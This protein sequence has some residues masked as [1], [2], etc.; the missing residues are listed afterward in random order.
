MKLTMFTLSL[1]CS[2]V[3]IFGVFSPQIREERSKYLLLSDRMREI[4]TQLEQLE[5]ERSSLKSSIQAMK[6]RTASQPSGLQPSA[7]IIQW[8]KAGDFSDVPAT[9]SSEL[10]NLLDL[11]GREAFDY[12]L[13]SKSTIETF[14]ISACQTFQSSR[15]SEEVCA[16][17]A[18]NKDERRQVDFAVS[19]GRETQCHM[20]QTATRQVVLRKFTMIAQQVFELPSVHKGL[21][22]C[23]SG[24]LLNTFL[25]IL[26]SRRA[27]KNN[28]FDFPE[29][30]PRSTLSSA[31][32]SLN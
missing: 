14:D 27:D 19:I 23:S 6:V 22:F 8:L 26:R 32:A 1:T 25:E 12:L 10:R 29:F 15:V 21:A 11:R 2:V 17:L 28:Q 4:T 13:I 5:T 16:I 9:C 18:L 7:Q 24:C 31:N 3:L 20:R 30:G